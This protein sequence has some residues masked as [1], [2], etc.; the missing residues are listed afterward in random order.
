M[1]KVTIHKFE[2]GSVARIVGFYQA[3]LGVIL[4][5]VI[6]IG[7]AARIFTE[8]SGFLQAF[9]ISAAFAAFAVVLLPALLFIVGWIQGVILAFFLNIIFR[10]SKG[11]ELMISEESMKRS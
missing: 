4:G 6:T 3:I 7:S 1:K 5:A 11:L 8:S 9:G 2:I 10:E